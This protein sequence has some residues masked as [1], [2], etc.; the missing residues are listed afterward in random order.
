MRGWARGQPH[1]RGRDHPGP[2][3]RRAALTLPGAGH[4][5]DDPGGPA[6]GGN[7]AGQLGVLRRREPRGTGRRHPRGR[8]PGTGGL[9]D[10]G[11]DAD[12]RSVRGQDGD[13]PAGRA[14]RRRPDPDAAQPRARPGDGVPGLLGHLRGRGRAQRPG[15][16]TVQ[17]DGRPPGRHHRGGRAHPAPRHRPSG[18]H[19]AAAP[20]GLGGRARPGRGP[21]RPGA[22]RAHVPAPGPVPGPRCPR[23]H[24]R[25][26]GHAD[27][28][29]R[30]HTRPPG[31][32]RRGLPRRRPRRAHATGSDG[33]PNERVVAGTRGARR[34]SSPRRSTALS[35][36]GPAT[37]RP[38]PTARHGPRA[39]PR[40]A[41]RCPARADS[42]NVE[43]SCPKRSNNP[44]PS[45]WFV[46]DPA[47]SGP[48]SSG[49]CPPCTGRRRPR[50][51]T[52]PAPWR[53]P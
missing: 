5:P 37:D 11:G 50:R 33:R 47:G 34:A 16:R 21:R 40:Q 30:A 1:H 44:P 52:R 4:R 27:G 9:A 24:R 49:T 28:R 7:R 2:A 53:A 36:G 45:W 51:G 25:A 48:V 3:D 14:R 46:V 35:P 15:L 12:P 26:P 39:R 32:P 20:G 42:T 6:P 22:E 31:H 17:A 41:S 29:L 38:A 23:G 19:D 43:G 13:G 10:D 8:G 18:D